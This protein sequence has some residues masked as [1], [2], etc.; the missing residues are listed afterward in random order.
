MRIRNFVQGQGMSTEFKE[1]GLQA[2]FKINLNVFN[3]LNEKY[4]CPW[5]YFHFDLNCGSGINEEI[6]CIGS[7]LAFLRATKETGC[8]KYFAGFCDTNQQALSKL[9]K[10]D[11][12]TNDQN[13]FLFHG[14]NASLI[15]AIPEIIRKYDHP[16]KAMGMV[17]SDPNGASIPIDELA[18]M[19]NECPRIDL[20]LNW[21]STQ[22][23]RNRGAFGDDRPT[24]SDAINK[25]NKRFWLIRQPMGR[26]QWTLLIG[27]NMQISEYPSLGFYHLNSSRGQEIFR[28]C[29][30]VRGVDPS[31]TNDN[32]QIDLW[33]Q[34]A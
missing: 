21:N 8:Q 10:Q 14:D 19:S 23:K 27:R 31:Q 33:R 6:G 20:V 28:R 22:F 11:E 16:Q 25:M 12:I 5:T 17:L 4:G 34:A 26:W 30:Y 1:R 15:S 32:D 24:L 2:A 13:C 9:I 29:N 7:P 18:W 3:G